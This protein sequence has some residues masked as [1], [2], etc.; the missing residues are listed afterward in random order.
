MGIYGL[1]AAVSL[2]YPAFRNA[3]MYSLRFAKLIGAERVYDTA[4]HGRATR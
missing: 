4:T 1:R 2:S 3:S